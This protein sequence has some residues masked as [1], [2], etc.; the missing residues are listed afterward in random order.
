[1]QNKLVS[2]FSHL[3]EVGLFLG[4]AAAMA[5]GMMGLR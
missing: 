4:A 2:I 5:A 1:M 3:A